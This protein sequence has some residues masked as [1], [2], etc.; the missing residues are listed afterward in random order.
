MHI[1]SI[2]TSFTSGGAETLVCNLS[3]QFAGSGHEASVAALADAR[4]VGNSVE[5]EQAMMAAVRQAGVHA[6]SLGLVRRGNVLTG[7]LALRRLL[8]DLRPDVIHA[9]TARVLPML[10]LARTRQPVILTHHNTRLSFPPRMFRFFDRCVHAYV[11]ITPG[12]A[13]IAARYARRPIR[14][15]PNAAS[16]SFRAATSRARPASIPTILSVGALTS[17]KD[18]PTLIQ[19]A[20]LLARALS[21]HPS[22]GRIRIVGGGALMDSLQELVE[23]HQA[24]SI[25]ELMGPRGDVRELMAAADLYV[26]CSLYE[27]MPI[28]VIEA[29]SSGLPV[30]ATDVP[31]NRELIGHGRNGLLVPGADPGRLADALASMLTDEAL[32]R[33]LSEGALASAAAFSIE[34]CAQAHVGLYGE[35]IGSAT[36]ARRVA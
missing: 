8:A 15:I 14:L 31:G 30:V 4:A 27:G 34:G 28:A 6:S 23:R 26:N 9:H 18:Y 3:R 2:L 35:A 16:E 7:A 19:A 22:S 11:A 20:P 12:C 29:L 21:P 13:A 24:G 17:Q 1:L 36:D 33:R 5:T 32:Y 10:W 25:V